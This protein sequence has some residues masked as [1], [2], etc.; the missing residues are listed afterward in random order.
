M[1]LICASSNPCLQTLVTMKHQQL[2]AKPFV[3][4][5]S[6]STWNRTRT[7]WWGNSIASLGKSFSKNQMI[8]CFRAVQKLWILRS[9]LDHPVMGSGRQPMRTTL[10]E[11]LRA[12]A[13]YHKALPSESHPHWRRRM[14]IVSLWNN[15]SSTVFSNFIH[16][17]RFVYKY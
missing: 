10:H 9:N 3:K 14:S 7:M 6:I 1:I 16:F 17:D 15:S 5:D 8:P 4:A 11:P 13:H 12:Q 2:P